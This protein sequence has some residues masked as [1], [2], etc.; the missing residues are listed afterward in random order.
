MP[1][2]LVALAIAGMLI[3]GTRKSATFNIVLVAIKL[4]AL[5]CRVGEVKLV[6]CGQG[7]KEPLARGSTSAS[8]TTG[9]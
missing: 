9:C 7:P 6:N 4:I 1:A 2:V 8:F 5:A 3:T